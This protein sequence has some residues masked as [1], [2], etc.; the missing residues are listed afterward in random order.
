VT[1]GKR[2]LFFFLCSYYP[3]NITFERDYAVA[4]SSFPANSDGGDT[5]WTSDAL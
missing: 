5:V 1:E 3:K 4:F 2:P